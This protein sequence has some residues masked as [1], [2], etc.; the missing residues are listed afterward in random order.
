LR[1]GE[2]LDEVAI[3]PE[4]R[5]VTAFGGQRKM[6]ATN[7]IAQLLQSLFRGHSAMLIHEHLFVYQLLGVIARMYQFPSVYQR[8]VRWALILQVISVLLAFM[9]LDTGLFALQFFG[10]SIAF[11]VLVG[12]LM[13]KRT[14]PSLAERIFVASGPMLIFWTMFFVG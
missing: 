6:F 13:F 1:R 7:H 8:S 11:W 4:P 2:H 14:H 9:V 3:T 12:I 10:L 5:A